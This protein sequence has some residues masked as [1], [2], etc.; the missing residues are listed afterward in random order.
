VASIGAGIGGAL[1]AVGVA[2]GIAAVPALRI[3]NAAYIIS[4]MSLFGLLG[5]AAGYL[6]TFGTADACAG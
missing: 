2:A 5:G 1:A 6:V 4:G 3:D